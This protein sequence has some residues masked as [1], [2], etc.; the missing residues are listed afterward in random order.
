MLLCH[1]RWVDVTLT[2]PCAQLNAI[3]SRAEML[4]WAFEPTTDEMLTFLIQKGKR[5]ALAWAASPQQGLLQP[6]SAL[7]SADTLQ[8]P[9][10]P[11]M[12]PSS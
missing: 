5:D 8:T 6:P 1:L 10:H 2:A 9:P 12:R 3:A 11:G 7:Q 4:A